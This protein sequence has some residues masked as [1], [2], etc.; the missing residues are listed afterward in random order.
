MDW[1]FHLIGLADERQIHTVQFAETSIAGFQLGGQVMEQGGNVKSG[2]S[3][4]ANASPSM[5]ASKWFVLLLLIIAASLGLS[6]Q[7]MSRQVLHVDETTQ[8]SGLSVSPWEMLKWLAGENLGR[9]GVPPDRMPPLAYLL[10]Q[11]WSVVAGNSII[12]FRVFSLIC[13]FAGLI[14]FAAVARRISPGYIGLAAFAVLALSANYIHHSVSIRPYSLFFALGCFGSY[15]V[16]RYIEVRHSAG[17]W[18]WLAVVA[19]TGVAAAY[20]HF[21]GIIMICATQSAL[22]LLALAERRSI[23]PYVAVVLSSAVLALGL[24]PILLATGEVK[25]SLPQAVLSDFPKLLY[26]LMASRTTSVY[27]PVQLCLIAGFTSAVVLAVL[28]ATK[29]ALRET[30]P[31]SESVA[32]QLVA[33][34]IVALSLSVTLIGAAILSGFNAL[35]PHY[36]I[37]LL[38]FLHALLLVPYRQS[39]G[40][41]TKIQGAALTLACIGTFAGV[42][43]FSR[44][45]Q[46]YLNGPSGVLQSLI[47]NLPPG[48]PVV[49]DNKRDEPWFYGSYPVHYLFGGKVPQY[50][51]DMTSPQINFTVADG[52]LHFEG[53]DLVEVGDSKI[54]AS[55]N[56]VILAQVQ[57]V[58]VDQATNFIRNGVAS[59]PDENR[60]Q[61]F[62]DRFGFE[63]IQRGYYPGFAA[64]RISVLKRKR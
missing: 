4:T 28:Q 37:W 64:A 63:I 38:P 55:K 16:L 13:A 26:R 14:S 31:M 36:Q 48:T 51:V 6:F 24:G 52:N 12:G 11:A 43:V 62:A 10:Q 32:F 9:F 5:S 39:N 46:V 7:L 33:L 58:R 61:I 17:G 3:Q 42:I 21:Y 60:D 29:S 56:Y 53:T 20:T 40:V 2:V 23:A 47:S 59:I 45:M 44:N 50:L 30:F 15:A 8:L 41:L 57:H 49:Y 34:T 22:A 19:A 18:R 27:L 54:L 1:F 35:E 25:T